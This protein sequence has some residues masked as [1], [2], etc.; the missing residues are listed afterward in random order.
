MTGTDGAGAGTTS[1]EPQRRRSR[2]DWVVDSIFFVV[3]TL[4]GGITLV[5]AASPEA[6]PSRGPLTPVVLTLDLVIGA[7]ACLSLWWRRRFP[8]T[9]AVIAALVAIVSTTS[10]GAGYLLVFTVAVHR[11]WVW[12]IP[13]VAASAVG[14]VAYVLVWTDGRPGNTLLAV[15]AVTGTATLAAVVG[16][17]MF[18]RARRLLVASLRERAER[19]EAEQQRSVQAARLGERT[20]IAREMHDVLAHRISLVSMHAGALEFRPDAE[21]DEVAVAA[22][23]IRHN[24]HLALQDLREVIGVL[25]S[26][27]D[28][29]DGTVP[30]DGSRPQPSLSALASLLDETRATGTVVT[31]DVDLPDPTDP[32]TGTA[33]PL[34]TSRTA[35]RVLQEGLTN[36]RKHGRGGVVRLRVQ[37]RPGDGLVAEV[38]NALRPAHA[39]P[40]GPTPVPGTGQGLVG[41]AERTTIAGG[42][43]EHGVQGEEF[44]LRVWLPWS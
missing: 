17:G 36:A 41:L 10:V 32:S 30:E 16:L 23:I 9:L 29:P 19:A 34:T 22:G 7:L 31:A 18:V 38:S 37:G 21:P 25:R 12:S 8:V 35:Y 33:V 11:R 44:R 3:A 13:V 24:A 20:R 28:L 40:P 27:P 26:D 5:L 15:L 6:D 14:S 42:R 1:T 43:M 4:T 39:T 2:R